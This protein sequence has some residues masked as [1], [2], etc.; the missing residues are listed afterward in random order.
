M[1]IVLCSDM[2]VVALMLFA[3]V[4]LLASLTLLLY[5]ATCSYLFRSKATAG[6]AP[7]KWQPYLNSGHHI[8]DVRS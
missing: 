3:L 2:R 7:L 5:T 8:T 4:A 6:P 1:S